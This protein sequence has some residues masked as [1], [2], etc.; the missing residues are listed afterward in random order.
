MDILGLEGALQQSSAP[1]HTKQYVMAQVSDYAFHLK[2][3]PNICP[4]MFS[5]APSVC[6]FTLPL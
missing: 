1:T 2:Y 3:L 6:E 4:N 5:L